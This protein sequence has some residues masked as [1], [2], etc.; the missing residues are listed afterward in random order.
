MVSFNIGVELGQLLAL[1][2]MLLAINYWRRSVSF[3][4]Y[5]MTANVML[6]FFGF[7]LTGYQLAGY[8]FTG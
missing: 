7:L 2:F 3:N 1:V 4:R 8:Y 5:A 6:L